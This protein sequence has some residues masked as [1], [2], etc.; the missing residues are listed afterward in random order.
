M[1]AVFAISFNHASDLYPGRA[2]PI[3]S[4]N[5][6]LIAMFVAGRV[7]AARRGRRQQIVE[8][9]YE[10]LLM[11]SEDQEVEAHILQA[12]SDVSVEFL[13]GMQ[14]RPL[15]DRISEAV[16]D[17]LEVDVSLIEVFPEPGE[18]AVRF[19]RGASEV[20]F[21]DEVYNEVVH[22]GK[23]LLINNLARYPQYAALQEQGVRS[24]II[25]PLTL[26]G[27]S[28]G[29]IGACANT[30]RSFTSRELR[31]LYSLASHVALLVGT[32]QLL[33]S[34]GKLSVKEGGSIGNLRHLKEQLS[35]ERQLQEREM[36]VA[37]RIQNDLLPGA[38]PRIAGLL[39]EGDSLPA[40]EVGGD[41]YDVLDLGDGRWGIAIADVSGKGVPAALVM[42]MTRTLLH[43]LAPASGS[44]A[45]VLT[46]M[47]THLYNETD[48]SVFV[49]M[50]Y[51]IWD[52]GTS[53]FTYSNAGHEPPIL[54][55]GKTSENFPSGG[56]ALGAMDEVGDVLEDNSLALG[57]NE[58]L[59]LFT[60]GATEAHNEKREMFG[61]TRLQEAFAKAT[62]R[63]GR[64]VPA[65]LDSIRSFAENASQHDDITM[66]CMKRDSEL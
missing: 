1:N 9:R 59:L 14:L 27:R 17:L 61:L 4:A 21:G 62:G 13:E 50:L 54:H 18:E 63:D 41:Y 2:L 42:V 66:L 44:P 55:T 8:R 43:S 12:I 65:V 34:V 23:S 25:A 22:K 64:V 30:R 51:G 49:S 45:E 47:N 31:Q 53:T 35:Y 32:T 26:R 10:R 58:A 38:L 28:I 24:V 56:I 7:T 33:H 6:L 19:V 29:L 11:L 46:K 16:H 60:D 37:R 39:L 20:V 52:T 57:E 40:K 5:F 48:P 36:E 15:L 3:L